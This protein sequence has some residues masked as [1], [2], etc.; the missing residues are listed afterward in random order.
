MKQETLEEA[1]AA[2]DELIV[3]V[4]KKLVLLQ[5]HKKGLQQLL[6]KDNET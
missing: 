5:E 2:I 1:L 4:A 3:L 6:E